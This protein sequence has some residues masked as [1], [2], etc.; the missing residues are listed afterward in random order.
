MGNMNKFL[1]FIIISAVCAVGGRLITQ[2]ELGAFSQSKEDP[3]KAVM[4]DL[5]KRDPLTHVV[6]SD[7][8]QE[9]EAIFQEA[10]KTKDLDAMRKKIGDL[11]REYGLPVQR[12][13]SDET[14]LA[15]YVPMLNFID[16]LAKHVPSGCKDFLMGFA[17]EDILNEPTVAP[18]YKN[19]SIARADIYSSG[20][21]RTESGT[22]LNDD[23]LQQIIFDELNF[24][25]E[26][27]EKLS[28]V[29]S[30][31]DDDACTL[32]ARLYDYKLIPTVHRAA[33]LRR[34]MFVE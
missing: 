6:L 11:F 28:D 13:A 1:R 24:S 29:Q 34:I 9:A 5:Q 15:L 14:T 31:S 12:R 25:E 8:P 20:K 4:A 2:I 10:F 16:V 32:A 3:V 26:D 18:V 33:Y 23:Q 22:F 7:H 30:I 21:Q 17:K 27:M 19:Y